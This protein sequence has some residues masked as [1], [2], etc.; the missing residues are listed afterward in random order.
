MKWFF[1]KGEKRQKKLDRLRQR[2][3]FYGVQVQPSGCKACSRLAGKV[4]A[5]ENAPKFPVYGC[6]ALVCNCEYLGAIDRR[7][8]GEKRS[9][10]DRREG[11]RMSSDRRLEVLDRRFT[12]G[13]GKGF[14]LHK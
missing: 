4:F 2:G 5:F 8:K 11:I 6:D 9:N 13:K 14:D 12:S 7:Q 10:R 3:L 1:N